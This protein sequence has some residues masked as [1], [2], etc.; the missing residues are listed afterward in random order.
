VMGITWGR[1][2]TFC[3][4]LMISTYMHLIDASSSKICM[5]EKVGKVVHDEH[6]GMRY[7]NTVLE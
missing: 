3:R 6:Y 4:K 1:C 5:K 2:F 7:R